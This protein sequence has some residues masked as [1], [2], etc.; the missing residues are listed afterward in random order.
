MAWQ[1]KHTK[2]SKQ[3]LEESA[4]SCKKVAPKDTKPKGKQLWRSW[5]TH[6]EMLRFLPF[7]LALRVGTGWGITPT[8]HNRALALARK[9]AAKNLQQRDHCALNWVSE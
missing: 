2:A 8:I 5:K 4:A 6:V 1:A 7:L 3:L 9:V